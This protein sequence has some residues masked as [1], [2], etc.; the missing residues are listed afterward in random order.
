MAQTL[1]QAVTLARRGVSAE[2]RTVA[3]ILHGCPVGGWPETQ[4]ALRRIAEAVPV[5]A[6]YTA[7]DL[8]D[9]LYTV[10]HADAH[11][12]GRYCSR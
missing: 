2:W 9:A 11:S 10:I 3:T 12:S 5:G 4:Q 1:D 8:V 6:A 7:D